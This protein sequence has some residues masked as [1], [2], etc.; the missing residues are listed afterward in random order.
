MGPGRCRC[1]QFW[2]LTGGDR[3]QRGGNSASVDGEV[4]ACVGVNGVRRERR[5]AVTAAVVGKHGDSPAEFRGGKDG[6]GETAGGSEAGTARTRLTSK[7]QPLHPRS[8]PTNISRMYLGTNMGRTYLDS[9][10][11][12]TNGRCTRVLCER[13]AA[14][15][16]ML[17]LRRCPRRR[18][19]EFILLLAVAGNKRI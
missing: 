9:R 11:G 13:T 15:A 5:R 16:V 17:P 19:S 10:S 1:Y 4:W 8:G 12:P 18:A 6:P 3:W 7:F 14:A 2:S